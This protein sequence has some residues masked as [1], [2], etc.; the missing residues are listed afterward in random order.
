MK[1][2]IFLIALACSSP[3]AA[4]NP[5]VGWTVGDAAT[6]VDC[7]RTTNVEFLR[8]HYVLE[9]GH[10]NWRAYREGM[11]NLRCR[12]TTGPLTVRA[13]LDVRKLVLRTGETTFVAVVAVKPSTDLVFAVVEL[14]DL[15]PAAPPTAN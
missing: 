7:P 2:L 8:R 11:E 4:Q 5:Y 15:V 10:L 3:G 9:N 13:T 1:R 12:W 14:R 6:V